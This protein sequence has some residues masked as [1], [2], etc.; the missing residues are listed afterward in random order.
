M[1][2][3]VVLAIFATLIL[4]ACGAT[5]EKLGLAPKA[6]DEFMIVPRAP[7]SLPPDYD[8]TPV[9]KQQPQK[10]NL[11]VNNLSESDAAFLAKINNSG[12]E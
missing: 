5:K 3:I 4:S 7:L 8:Y 6:P 11:K 10:D 2:K 9:S 1:K 12:R